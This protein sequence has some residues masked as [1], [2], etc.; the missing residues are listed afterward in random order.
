VK[1]V[2]LFVTVLMMLSVVA[3]VFADD[4]TDPAVGSGSGGVGA[5]IASGF[6]YFV[7]HYEGIDLLWW[8]RK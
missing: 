3:P 6:K 1:R 4:W 7:Q 8:N 2:L 5:W